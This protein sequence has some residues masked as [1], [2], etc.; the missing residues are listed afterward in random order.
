MRVIQHDIVPDGDMEIIL[1]GH[2]TQDLVPSVDIRYTV[3]YHE[4]IL[5]TYEYH[6]VVSRLDPIKES[7]DDPTEVRFRVSSRHLTLVSPV[8]KKMI[9]GSWKES[10]PCESRSDSSLPDAAGTLSPSSV[11]TASDPS[12]REITTTGWDAHALSVVLNIIHGRQKDVPRDL[13]LEFFA[14]VAAIVNYYNC[15]EAVHLAA[16]LWLK[17]I[18]EAPDR[19][20]YAPI[21]WLFIFRVFECPNQFS[22]MARFVLEHGEGS[23]LVAVN[24]LPVG[25]LLGRL[26][27]KRQVI[28][29]NI[30]FS[31]VHL[32]EELKEGKGG[33][34]H[35]CQVVMFGQLACE[36]HRMGK[37]NPPLDVDSEIST[38]FTG[39]SIRH[40]IT[41]L[42]NIWEIEFCD[43]DNWSGHIIHKC[44]VATRLRPIIE[45]ALKCI[46]ELSIANFQ[47]EASHDSQT[48]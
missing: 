22:E 3:C 27:D 44:S 17:V 47:I 36:L 15:A 43:R 18:Y 24:D 4:E 34:S 19:Y 25:E 40:I 39:Y 45:E 33:C 26:D 8:F 21:M 2:S 28:I 31:V 5:D 12:V 10:F 37:L 41:M 32:A 46:N 29:K 48:R 42:E 23:E 7:D 9:E 11:I 20:G 38:G 13:D 14:S 30:L 6:Q 1:K 16:E 35:R